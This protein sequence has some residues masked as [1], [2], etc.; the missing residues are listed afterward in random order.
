MIKIATC[1]YM[2]FG[3]CVELSELSALD[4]FCIHGY[5]VLT[6]SQFIRVEWVIFPNMF[7][8]VPKPLAP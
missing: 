3:L 6:R 2:E 4:V 7:S 8:P 1:M 5:L